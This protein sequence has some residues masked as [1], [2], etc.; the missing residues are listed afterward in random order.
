MA[1]HGWSRFYYNFEVGDAN[2]YLS[3]NEG[4]PEL[5][6]EVTRGRY[7]PTLG[8]DAV[9]AAMSDVGSQAYVVSMDRSTR[10]CTISA[11]GPFTL[12][13]GTGTTA[14][15]SV[16]PTLGFSGSNVGPGLTFTSK[17]PVG[18]AYLPQF[19]LQDWISPDHFKK[20]IDSTVKKTASGAVEVVTFGLERF[21]QA[22]IRYA[23][24]KKMDGRVIR[25]NPNGVEDLVA[26]MD[27]MI[28]KAALE[29]IPDDTNPADFY[30]VILERT[31]D[32]QT[33]VDYRLKEL[34]DKNLPDFFETGPLVFRV[35]A[36]S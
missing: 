23:T 5:I 26:L 11:P 8:L 16:F 31:G 24:N 29:I 28:T 17:A 3:F 9:A 15:S 32:S 4:G 6:A 1:V 34:F 13:I 19:K 10:L 2:R 22:H 30:T 27:W 7:A 36:E 25:N 21:I 14:A 35:I 18:S 33:G 20:S 12:M